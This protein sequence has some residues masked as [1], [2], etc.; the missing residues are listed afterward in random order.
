[1]KNYCFLKIGISRPHFHYFRLFNTVENRLTNVLFKQFWWLDSNFGPL[2][3]EAT[4]QPTEPQPLP[5]RFSFVE[6][7]FVELSH[8]WEEAFHR[9]MRWMRLNEADWSFSGKRQSLMKIITKGG[10]SS[11]RLV[12]SVT[13]FGEILPKVQTFKILSKLWRVYLVFG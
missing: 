2:V 12:I 7:S 6:L 11:S 3:S 5:T 8:C 4:V 13:R 10:E 1:M 9:R